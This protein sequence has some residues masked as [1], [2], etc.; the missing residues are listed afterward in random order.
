MTNI[1]RDGF[2][3]VL[4]SRQI[5]LEEANRGRGAL[6][7]ETSADELDRIQHA[8]VRDSALDNL[9]RDSKR[10]REV[11]AA[12]RRIDAGTFG[13]CLDCEDVISMKRLAAV[14]WTASCIPWTA[15]SASLGMPPRT[16]WPAPTEGLHPKMH[17]LRAA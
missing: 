11:R 5:E 8:Q 15:W 13:I 4:K 1:D 9:D 6:V 14:P 7:I 3:N 16:C 17:V 10:F 2:R 12:L